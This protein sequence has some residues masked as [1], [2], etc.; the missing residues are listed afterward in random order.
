M[1][2]Q[3][4]ISTKL[5]KK[6]KSAIGK[7]QMDDRVEWDFTLAF[8]PNTPPFYYLTLAIPSPILGSPPIMIGAIMQDPTLPQ[9]AIDNIIRNALEAMRTER[10]KQLHSPLPDPAGGPE[11][12][13]EAFQAQPQG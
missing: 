8:N 2:V 9:E 10:T 1:P 13:L 7:L 11:N 6:L 3:D 4:R 12:L 5:E